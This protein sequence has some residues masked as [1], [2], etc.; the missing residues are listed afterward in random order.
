MR[1]P[2]RAKFFLFAA[3]IATAPLA[4]V[5]ENLVRITRDELKS[6]ANEQL[7]GVAGQIRSDFDSAFRGRWL[8]PLM[9]IRNGIDSPSLDVP[10]KISL[11][12]LGLGQIPDVVAIQ[13]TVTG[14]DLPILVTDQDFS[15][16]LTAAGLDPVATLR[17][18]APDIAAIR[19]DRRYGR[20]VV[21]Q[22][23]PTG[24]WLATVALPLRT[25]FSGQSLTLSA[26]ISLAPLGAMVRA[27]PF[28][29]RG[30]VVVIDAAGRTVLEAT[31]RALDERGIVASAVG[32][33]GGAARPDALEPY[34]RPDGEAM[35]GAYAFP[36][37][38]P[39]AVIAELSER[40]AYAVVRQ[41]T[42][43]IALVGG[44]GFLVAAFASVLFAGRLTGPILRIGEAANRVGLGDLSTRVVGVRSKDEI[45]DLAERMNTMIRELS[46]RMQ[47]MKFVSRGTV[48]AIRE[49]DAT[50]MARGGQR[51]RVALLFSDIRGYTAFSESVA[52]E[53]VVEMLNLYLETQTAIVEKHGGDVDKF[54]GDEV[55]A[56][57]QGE[58]ME[59]R[60]V[61]CA[62]EI[63]RALAGL[64]DDHPEW[65]LHVGVGISAGEV[66]LGAMGA[67]ERMDFTV[68]GDTV[69]LAARLCDAAPPDAVLVSAPVREAL[70]G[71]TF[72]SFAALAPIALKGKRDPVVVFAATASGSAE[73]AA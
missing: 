51:R 2:L 27:H 36:E 15:A 21:E 61:A 12:T 67:R 52:P 50:G 49:A 71:E 9:L 11:L 69:N 16:K 17:T 59:R 32:L 31:P 38:F 18:P 1:F 42:I 64:L 20:P 28:A 30:E 14:S 25:S 41:M 48:S 45:G 39:W 5:G 72:V 43:N 22:L 34:V 56:V 53:V 7:T 8:T 24:D 13:L 68:L 62:L 40:N 44:A 29:R 10:Q 33:I 66:V 3:L 70:A 19:E 4:L 73:E 60:A 47:L 65:N 6:A 23:A 58:H 26:R 35:L 63:Q 57:F 55:I 46:E 54:V 37:A